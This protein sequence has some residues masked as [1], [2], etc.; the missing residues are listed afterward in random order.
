M[1][2]V[3]FTGM[4]ALA[5]AVSSSIGM[6]AGPPPAPDTLPA[7]ITTRQTL[8]SI[9]F[10]IDRAQQATRAPVEVQLYVSTDRG[11]NWQMC[12]RARPEKGH[13]LFRAITDGE[14][15]F[16]IRTLDGSG[17][18]RPQRTDGPGLRVVVDTSLP[19]LELQARQGEAGQIVV[20]WQVVEPYLDP[21]SLKIQYRSGATSPWESVAIDHESIITSGP[22]RTGDVIW[23]PESSAPPIGGAFS[24][25]TEWAVEIR[26]EVSD[27]AGNSAV[28]HAKVSLD[29]L[30]S[31]D[32][33]LGADPN[34][35]AAAT[36]GGTAR[37]PASPWR[38]SIDSPPP[39]AA[40]SDLP[41]VP[42]PPRDRV[43]AR[44]QPAQPALGESRRNERIGTGVATPRAGAG[45]AQPPEG[46]VAADVT[47]AIR[48]QYATPQQRARD[49]GALAVPPGIEPQMVNSRLFELEY[50]V[51][52]VGPS[53]IQ[54]VEL[55]GTCDGGRTWRSFG[56]DK[57]RQSP[58]LVTVRDEGLYGFRVAVQNSTGLGGEK[59]PSGDKPDVWIGVDLTKPTARILSAE[60]GTG[61]QAGQ[62]I[63]RWKADDQMLS[64]RP[65]SIAC[66]ET[67]SGPW[68]TIVSG[69]ENTGR[70]C[71]SIDRR[72]PPQIY[73]LLEV[74]D[75]AGNL[76]TFE[77]AEAV[78]LAP[79][80]PTVQIGKVRP[81]VDSVRRPSTRYRSR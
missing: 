45:S 66:S 27:A 60:R 70:Y 26:A 51:D 61:D 39:A 63:I 24:C 78:A 6:G 75:R 52:S 77:T 15:W 65:V 37:P 49:T 12:N 19:Q 7:P 5:L 71:W 47:P 1:R 55:W 35:D 23:W 38:A 54:R 32:S 59:P 81:V 3:S 11:A 30:A 69:L 4:L 79:F 48:N 17:Q 56:A 64:L 9:P 76:G 33:R 25:P 22:T 80:R 2:L 74:R 57:D 46:S 43:A 73:L 8:F 10:Q 31:A 44:Q 53:G 67:P 68:S 28:S 34:R 18:L 58:M 62:L 13:F 36:I 29:R 50:Q 14:Y 41:G 72:L 40:R 16:L 42:S 20:R 21:D